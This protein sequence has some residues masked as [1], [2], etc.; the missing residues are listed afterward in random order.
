MMGIF[1]LYVG[2]GGSVDI[3]KGAE[4]ILVFLIFGY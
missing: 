4:I 1:G 3:L 2:S